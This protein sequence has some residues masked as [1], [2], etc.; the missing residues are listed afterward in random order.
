MIPYEW[1]RRP[2]KE[3]ILPSA[4][5]VY[6]LFL[7]DGA[8]LPVI[9]PPTDRLI[10]IGLGKSLARRCH[11]RGRTEGHSPRRSLA[12]LVCNE[13]KLKPFLGANG[14]YK[15]DQEGERRLDE[16]MHRNLLMAFALTDDLERVEGELIVRFAPPLNLNK[17]AQ[18]PSHRAVSSLRA[19]LL[20]RARNQA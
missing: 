12:A 14:N 8:K 9:D 7:R 10:Y 3:L 11:F 16:W 20:E 1:P 19:S 2:R 4:P 13:L 15:F 5:G 18:S 17:C 6:A